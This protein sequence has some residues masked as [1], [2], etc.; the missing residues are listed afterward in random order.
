MRNIT[1]LRG[2]LTEI[3]WARQHSKEAIDRQDSD[4]LEKAANEGIAWF[5]GILAEIRRQRE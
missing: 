3:W 5:S 4:A 1:L 2:M